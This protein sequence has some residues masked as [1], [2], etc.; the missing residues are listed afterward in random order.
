VEHGHVPEIEAVRADPEDRHYAPFQDSR[1]D[2][3]PRRQN[4]RGDDQRGGDGDQRLEMVVGGG[5][6]PQGSGGDDP[7][8]R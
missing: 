4:A 2:S 1:D 3:A 6:H 7:H 8:V 5:D